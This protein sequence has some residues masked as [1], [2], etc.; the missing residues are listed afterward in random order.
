MLLLEKAPPH[1]RGGNSFFTAGRLPVH[2]C[3]AGG[4]PAGRPRRP[5][6]RGSGDHRRA[7]VHERAVPR[8]PHAAD[9]GPER[10][11]PGGR[12]D[13]SVAPDGRVDARSRRPVD[14]HAGPP[15]VPG[16]RASIASGAG[17]TWRR[18]AA[19]R[20]WSRRSTR[21]RSGWASRCATGPRRPGFSST[22]AARSAGVACR[23]PDGFFEVTRPIG[24]AGLGGLR[25]EPGVADPVPRPGLG[26]RAACA[27]P[28][29]TRATGSAW[30]STRAPRR[31][32]TGRAATRWPGTRGPR[33]SATAASATCSRSTRIPLG[34]IVNVRGERFVDEG[35]DFRN[36]TYAEVRAGDPPPAAAA[37]PSRSSTRRS[38]RSCARSTGS[39]R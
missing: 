7:A 10:R 20:A 36:Y 16:G 8:R 38:C 35:A 27:A 18:W 13:R 26:A 30:R 17:S 22:A 28:G 24:R 5:H 4:S 2:P 3:R 12:P 33:R 9:G 37:R 1:E 31:T 15:V 23:G 21:T 6:R 19:A 14:P 39:A 25:G 29:T 11:R 34:L 32:A